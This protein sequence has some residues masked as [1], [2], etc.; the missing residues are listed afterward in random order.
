MRAAA[1]RRRRLPAV[2]VDPRLRP[3]G[4]APAG[5]PEVR[6]G[7]LGHCSARALLLRAEGGPSAATQSSNV[8]WLDCSHSLVASSFHLMVLPSG[9]QLA[10]LPFGLFQLVIHCA[11]APLLRTRR[12]TRR[13]TQSR[14]T[15]VEVAQHALLDGGAVFITGRWCRWGGT[16]DERGCLEE[17]ARLPA[18]R[19][20]HHRPQRQRRQ[21]CHI[22]ILNSPAGYRVILKYGLSRARAV[23]LMVKLGAC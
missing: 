11:T 17:Q 9:A 1:S 19:L 23:K 22:Q 13:R 21:R 14:L 5:R 20:L 15:Q 18:C 10:M 8:C 16:F 2:H 6:S 7:H 3:R 4:W 12:R